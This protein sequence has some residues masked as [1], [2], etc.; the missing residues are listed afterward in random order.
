MKV[1]FFSNFLNHHQLPLCEG[2]IKQGIDFTFVATEKIPKERLDMGYSDMNALPFV[3]REYE[4]EDNKKIA[5][6]L[7]KYSDIMIFGNVDEKYAIIREKSGKIIYRASERFFKKKLKYFHPLVYINV[8]KAHTRTKNSYLLCLS[9]FSKHDYNLVGAYKGR[10]VK[11]GYFPKTTVSVDIGDKKENSI[12]WAGRMIP[13]KKPELLLKALKILKRKGYCFSCKFI[14][15][16]ELKESLVKKAAKYGLDKEVIFTGSLDNLLVRKEMEEA[17]IFAFTSNRE[18]GWGAV[19][20]E[21]MASDVAVVS[22]SAVGSAPY[23]I[24]DGENGLIFKSGS[25]KDLA[26][27]LSI[28]LSDKEFSKRCALNASK[29]LKEVW[30]GEEAAKRLIEFDR[31]LKNGEYPYYDEGP[32]SKA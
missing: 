14:G 29:T 20:N 26:K 4:S 13:W 1:V 24:K 22:S 32:C 8:N 6:D 15:D 21:A 12:L 23:L 18:E 7:A 2:F 30:N 27:K 10:C 11:W 19:L 5:E 25:A 17:E 16:G 31:K 3:L 9:A 28:Y